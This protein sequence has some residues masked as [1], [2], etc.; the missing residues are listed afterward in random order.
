MTSKKLAEKCGEQR[1][2]SWAHCPQPSMPWSPSHLLGTVSRPLKVAQNKRRRRSD[3]NK[4]MK[5]I[6]LAI[7]EQQIP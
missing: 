6:V 2:V 4:N 3:T 1:M 5:I 7:T